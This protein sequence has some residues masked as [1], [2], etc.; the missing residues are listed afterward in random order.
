MSNL[1]AQGSTQSRCR[2]PLPEGW[3]PKVLRRG[4]VSET[5]DLGDRNHGINCTWVFSQDGPILGY[6]T[7]SNRHT[8]SVFKYVDLAIKNGLWGPAGVATKLEHDVADLLCSILAPWLTDGKGDLGVRWLANGSDA[9]DAA[10]RLARA[11]TRRNKFVSIGYHGSSV[12]FAHRPQN[13]GVPKVIQ[14]DRIDIE[15]GDMNAIKEIEDKIA[16]VIVEVPGEDER[17][18]FFLW[19]LKRYCDDNGAVLILDDIVTGFRLALGGAGEHYKV[20]ADLVCLGKAMANGR[21]ISA[22]VGWPRLMDLLADKVFYSNTFNGDAL[23]LAFVQ[24]TLTYLKRYRDQ[25][26]P[27]IWGLGEKL[28]AA[29][30]EVGIKLVGHAPRMDMQFSS[31]KKRRQ[32]CADM[33][34]SG[35]MVD[36]PFYISMAHKDLHIEKT[37]EAAR[38]VLK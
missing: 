16:A 11:A 34:E 4:A 21:G 32:F 20:K 24:G 7:R 25:V 2:R 35:I 31:E 22:L 33:V 9:C 29:M 13:R 38:S 30:G 1:T 15:F 19:D 28:K 36:R 6:S 12:L 10:V 8:R 5:W 23:N 18:Q 17:A 37:V 14:D 27:Y 3:N 26:Y